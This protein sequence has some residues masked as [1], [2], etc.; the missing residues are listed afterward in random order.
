MSAIPRLRINVLANAAGRLSSMALAILCT[1]LYI[2]FLG[3]EAYGLIGFYITLQAS[4]SFLEMGLSRAC[5]RELAHCSG[6]G[7][8]VSREM[9][10]T[11]RSLEIIYWVVALLI[12]MVL[13]L[14][15]SW[16]AS[17]WLHSAVFSPSD[18]KGCIILMAWVIALRWPMGIYSGALMGLQRQVLM[19]GVQ[20]ASSLL[21][22]VG[23]VVVL[24]LV[25]ADVQTFFLWQLLVAAC[26]TGMF[27]AV[28]WWAM[29]GTF[30]AGRFSLVVI[31]RVASFAAGVGG[32]AILGT[33]LL[34][35]DKLIL[36]AFLPLKQFGY[37]AL[38]S[39]IANMVSMV[40][41]PVSNAVFPRFSQHVG[42]DVPSSQVSAL[43]HLACQTVAV[44]IIPSALVIAL[45]PKEVLYVYTGAEDIASQAGL[46]L[47]ILVVAKMLHALML[48]PY[49]LQLAYAWVRLS[50]YIN[51]VTVLWFVP[52]VYFLAGEYGST[53]AAIARLM[54]TIGYIVIGLP[55]MHRRL[56]AGELG[57]WMWRTVVVPILA[58]GS[59][60]LVVRMAFEQF[61]PG[62][63]AQGM[64]LFLSAIFA[65]ALALFSARDVRNWIGRQVFA[66]RNH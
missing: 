45:F 55:L 47:S 58:A 26:S 22:W 16:L 40:A 11:L 37:Y 29:P 15:S 66:W 2:H 64:L 59:L 65:L 12:G 60:L 14:I 32:N 24:W 48:V 51:I 62:R 1:P 42:G 18:L 54:V 36:S 63:V 39:V 8:E 50:L 43:Y 17:S 19:N 9:L 20:F 28:A 46:V 4:L 27:A 38:A 23:S 56:L 5:N 21:G 35:A 44:L 41:N 33:L 61:P 25:H 7:A 31:R 30:G 52:V 57:Q 6:R 10:D 3:I 49:S 34:Q 53:G 13:T